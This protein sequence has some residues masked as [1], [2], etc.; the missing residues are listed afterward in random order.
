[1]K[2]TTM[3]RGL[4]RLAVR[5]SVAFPLVLAPAVSVTILEAAGASAPFSQ[6]QAQE[7][8]KPSKKKTRKVPAMRQAAYKKLEKAQEAYDAEDWAGALAALKDMDASKKR[9]NGYEIA[10]MYNL[11]GVVYYSMERYKEAIPY[12]KKVLN[13]G[14]KNL[15][16]ALEEST[17]FTL[18]QLYF[19]TENYKQAVNYL[20]QWMKVSDRVTADSYALRAQAY[21]QT[22]DQGKALADINVAVSM[23]EREGKVPKENWY[24]LQQYIYFERNDY[25]SVAAVLEKMLQHYPKP[26]YYVTLAAMY[27][28]LKRD[29]DQ[30]HMMEAAYLAGALQKE[31]DLLNM[32]YLFMGYEMPYKGAKVISKGIK[33]KKIPRNA[34]NLETLAQAY[35]MAQELQKAIPQLEAAAKLS[36]KGQ[37]Y[38][39]LASIY[40]DLDENEKAVAAGKKALAKGGVKRQDQLYVVM[41]MANAN[42]KQYDAALSSLKKALKDKRSERTAR[43]WIAFVEGE[44][45]REEK[46][47]I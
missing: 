7:Q 13:Q 32:G 6:A 29:R 24:G 2:L 45:A 38:S 11:F 47:A 10:Q 44:K 3:A 46:L 21:M 4:S 31:K 19:V 33:E 26:V 8:K 36:D 12:F 43:Q 20:N 39:R 41:G 34:K 37:I 42:L 23:Y 5:V 30:L 17:L 18:A 40:L 9:Y 16:V 1:M 14:E 22:G 27:G 25:K 28:E 15:S 35:Q